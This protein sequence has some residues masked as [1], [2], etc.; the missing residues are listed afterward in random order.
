MGLS[1]GGFFG[2]GSSQSKAY[3]S[4]Q[5]VEGGD[6]IRGGTT[7]KSSQT[8]TTIGG[9][10]TGLEFLTSGT[11]S[12]AVGGN[13]I[14]VS[15]SGKSSVNITDGGA[16]G[17]VE[18]LIGTAFDSVK[19]MSSNLTATAEQVVASVLDG[20]KSFSGGTTETDA[21]IIK[22]GAFALFGVAVY[23]IWKKA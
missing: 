10:T 1:T 12:K 5:I 15:A 21:K 17:V 22:Y 3:D 19:Q 2:G 20:A 18:N 7:A 16:F 23:Y 8:Q 11:R 13:L 9:T 14:D 6:A 4:K